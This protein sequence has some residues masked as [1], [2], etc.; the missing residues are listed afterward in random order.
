VEKNGVE[1]KSVKLSLQTKNAVTVDGS[2]TLLVVSAGATQSVTGSESLSISL[3]EPSKA[4]SAQN[5][6]PPKVDVQEQLK[7][8]I[9]HVASAAAEVLA[10]DK[11]AA[12]HAGQ[13]APLALDAIVATV[14]F[15]VTT[16]EKGG[17]QVQLGAIK[18]GP[19]VTG[20]VSG[21]QAIELTFKKL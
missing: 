5:A 17:F 13:P 10:P 14:G 19:T 7:S 18:V 6:V 8:A 3:I 4:I 2:L 20:S 1:L 9:E 11:A 12:P 16:T 21:S 15:D